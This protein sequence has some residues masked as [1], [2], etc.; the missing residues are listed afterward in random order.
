MKERLKNNELS[1]ESEL[2]KSLRSGDQQMLEQIYVKHYP[3]MEKFVVANR[4]TAEAA[5]DVFQE[6]ILVLYR[7]AMKEGFELSCRVETYLYAVVRRLWL[8]ELRMQ[9][10]TTLY[11]EEREEDWNVER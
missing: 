3:M 4:G 2:I 11:K 7:N 6:A 10:R 9:G 1:V 5:R 8:K